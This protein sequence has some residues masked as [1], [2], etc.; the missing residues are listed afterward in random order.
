MKHAHGVYVL[1][2]ELYF[3]IPVQGHPGRSGG[4]GLFLPVPASIMWLNSYLVS[5]SREC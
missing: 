2:G 1:V 5:I 3:V 4:A